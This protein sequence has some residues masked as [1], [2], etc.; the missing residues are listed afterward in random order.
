M[1][2]CLYTDDLTGGVVGVNDMLGPLRY[3]IT[4]IPRKG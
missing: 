4:S 3:D 1:T 2:K